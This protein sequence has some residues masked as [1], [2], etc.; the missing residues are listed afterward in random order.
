MLIIFSLKRDITRD[1]G[2]EFDATHGFVIAAMN[3]VDAR[4]YA[5]SYRRMAD[6]D[7]YR[8]EA[9]NVWT[10]PTTTRTRLGVAE[11]HITPGVILEDHQWG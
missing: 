2:P 1:K 7:R 4:L 5:A 9:P 3:E 8:D 11:P 6:D 10:A